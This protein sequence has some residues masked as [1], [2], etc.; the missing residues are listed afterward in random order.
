[1]LSAMQLVWVREA[2]VRLGICN[3]NFLHLLFTL[4]LPPR[5]A[6]MFQLSVS[7]LFSLFPRFLFLFFMH[8]LAANV[9]YAQFVDCRRIDRE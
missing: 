7:L 1:M 2:Y 3:A 5:Q 9:W 4:P 6:H 8:T